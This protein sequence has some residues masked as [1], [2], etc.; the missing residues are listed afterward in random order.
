[1]RETHRH[2][3]GH[4]G[5]EHLALLLELLAAARERAG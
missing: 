5:R 2:Q 1:V 4:V 3:L